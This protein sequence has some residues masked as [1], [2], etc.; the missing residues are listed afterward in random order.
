MLGGSRVGPNAHVVAV[1]I[2]THRI[3]LSLKNLGATDDAAYFGTQ[4]PDDKLTP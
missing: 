4:A 2:E 1:D 3:P